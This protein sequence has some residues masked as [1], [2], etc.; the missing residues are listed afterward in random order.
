MVGSFLNK[1][2]KEEECLK[3][4]DYFKEFLDDMMKN[5]SPTRQKRPRLDNVP[6]ISYAECSEDS[7][8]QSDSSSS[9]SE[10]VDL[11]SRTVSPLS[12]P[13]DPLEE[14]EPET[15][16]PSDSISLD[17]S[18]EQTFELSI[19]T[20]EFIDDFKA[21]MDK[22]SKGLLIIF[23]GLNFKLFSFRNNFV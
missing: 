19:E 7:G 16:S 9:V 13:T 11:Y 12:V 18:S 5:L 22:D 10:T 6:Q 8:S 2:M 23:Q 1:K 14:T 3:L 15:P 20:N 4:L 21:A 17:N